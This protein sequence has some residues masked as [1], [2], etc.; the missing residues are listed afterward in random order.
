MRANPGRERYLIS[1]A[2]AARTLTAWIAYKK[3]YI[4]DSWHW[5][6]TEEAKS[7]L[8]W[9]CHHPEHWDGKMEWEQKSNWFLQ[10]RLHYRFIFVI[11]VLFLLPTNLLKAIQRWSPIFASKANITSVFTVSSTRLFTPLNIRLFSSKPI[12]EHVWPPSVW[13]WFTVRWQTDLCQPQCTDPILVI[14]CQELYF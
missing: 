1:G 9:S 6:R 13:K 3:P 8:T 2:S 4:E 12:T 14:R 11:G 7:K 5:G 10:S